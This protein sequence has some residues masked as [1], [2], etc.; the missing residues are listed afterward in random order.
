M[1]NFIINEAWNTL[2]EQDLNESNMSQIKDKVK[3]IM[4]IKMKEEK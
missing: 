3:A 2:K 1:G 4:G